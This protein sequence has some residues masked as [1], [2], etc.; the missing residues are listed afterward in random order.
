M[1]ERGWGGGSRC[2]DISGLD[3]RWA[4]G[5]LALG[6]LLE[7]SDLEFFR[8]WESAPGWGNG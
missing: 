3:A 1:A 5:A 8:F 7:F 4:A 6:P 2:T